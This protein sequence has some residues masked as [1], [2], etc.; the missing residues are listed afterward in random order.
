MAF[1]AGYLD[2]AVVQEGIDKA[3]P[4]VDAAAPEPGEVFFQRFRLDGSRTA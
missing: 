3:V 2:F 4:L 1:A